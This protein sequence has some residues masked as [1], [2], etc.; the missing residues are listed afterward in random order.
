MTSSAAPRPTTYVSIWTPRAAASAASDW[1]RP[2]V[3]LPSLTSTMRFCVSSGNSA[4][5][6]R[7]APPMSVDALGRHGREAVDV[8]ELRRQPLDERVPAEGDDGGLVA[9]FALLER[10]AHEGEGRFAGRRRRRCRTG[11]RRRPWSADR[12][13]AMSCKPASAKT[14]AASIVGAQ[15]PATGAGGPLERWCRAAAL[16]PSVNA[17]SR[18]PTISSSGAVSADAVA[19]HQAALPLRKVSGAS[20]AA[21][22]QC[23]AHRHARR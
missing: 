4:E 9:A 1:P 8:V 11:R 19:A 14:S 7:R 2:V 21:R 17:S 16:R 13:G 18:A 15:R 10:V 22:G 12:P 6:S 23:A 20:H 5:A 3:S